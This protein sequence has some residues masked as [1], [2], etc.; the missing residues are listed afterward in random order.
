[1]LDYIR[2]YITDKE[3]FDFR[4]E[5]KKPVGL[6]SKIDR[7]TGE[8]L[9]FPKIGIFQNMELRI[10]KKSTYIKGS[11]HKM[12]NMNNGLEKQNYDILNL[13]GN[14]RALDTLVDK[15]SIRPGET[16]ITNLEFGLNIPLEYDPSLFIENS[17]MWDFK[18]PSKIS[19]FGGAGYL[20]EFEKNDYSLKI[21]NKSKQYKLSENILRIEVKIIKKR[22]LHD[23][24]IF[25]LEDL[26][27]SESYRRLFKFLIEQFDKLLMIDF[28]IL[29]KALRED[30]IHILKQYTNPHYW[31]NLQKDLSQNGY[32]KRKRKCNEFITNYSFDKSKRKVKRLLDKQFANNMDCDSYKLAA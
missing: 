20:K 29:R 9:E 8:Y 6:F 10:A 21:Y 19:F 4:I 14:Y 18:A 31:L 16:T 7:E 25:S 28:L 23:L 1:M 2:F 30:E 13:C 24:G 12:Q 15:F 17:I 27:E 5:K 22:K 11:L 32:Y 26:Y 3:S